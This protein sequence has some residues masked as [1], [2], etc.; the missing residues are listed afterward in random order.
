MRMYKCME[1]E[2]TFKDRDRA[3][4]HTLKTKHVVEE[5]YDL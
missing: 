5:K 4:L 1:C 2:Q 3:C